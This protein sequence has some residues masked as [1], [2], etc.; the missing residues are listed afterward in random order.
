M[1]AL[2]EVLENYSEY[3]TFLEDRFGTRILDFLEQDELGKIGFKVKEGHEHKK[4]KEW[5]EEN[6]LKQLEEDLKFG[7]MK[8]QDERGISAGLMAAVVRSWCKV[9]ENG[10]EKVDYGWYGD[11]LFKTV[12]EKYNINL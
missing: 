2:K 12:A 10:L 8:G 6:I 7:W 1:K 5:T 3:E 9:L 11:N 4:T